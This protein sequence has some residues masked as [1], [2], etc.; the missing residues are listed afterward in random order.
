M[1][2]EG[3]YI[4][5]GK[6]RLRCG[7]TTGSCATAA[8]LASTQRLMNGRWPDVVCIQ[9]PAGIDYIAHPEACEFS[10][11]K[12]SA[13][14]GI[15]KDAGDD[16]DVTEGRL[17]Y[18]QVSK[19]GTA[20]AV[21]IEAGEGVGRVTRAGLD[22]MPGEAAINSVPRKMIQDQLHSFV[23]GQPFGLR[24][25]ISVEEGKELAKH[26]FNPR[27]GIEGGISIL[28][29][30]G[31]VRPMS[32]EALIESVKL[33]IKSIA[34]S[35]ARNIVLSPGNY[36]RAYCDNEL[37]LKNAPIALCSNYIGQ[38][39][40]CAVLHG[41][42]TIVL[43]GHFG[44]LAKVACGGMNTHSSVC[45]GRFEVLCT[46][47]ALCGAD[48]ELIRNMYK[49]VTVDGALE[50]VRQAR[51]DREVL[52]SIALQLH[53][54]LSYRAGKVDIGAVFFSQKYGM[55]GA[56]PQIDKLLHK[57]NNTSEGADDD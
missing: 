8:A 20:G 57:F 43:V 10:S 14:C 12:N 9:T 41:F 17:I 22:Q 33:E 21:I 54:H 45:D 40:D 23:E 5:V 38:A 34:A 46:H 53:K 39:I 52:D 3:H 7:F 49:E 29:T 32:E 16:P 35:G 24:V 47:A 2:S 26:T 4:E 28:G 30:S 19:V 44:K 50:Y 48:V 51:L 13:Q 55:L 27:L 36:G 31:I 11:D 25:E 18:A 37:A 15:R 1:V 56:T 6:T 42:E